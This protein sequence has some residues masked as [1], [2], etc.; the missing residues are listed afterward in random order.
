MKPQ[1]PDMLAAFDPKRHGGELM[2][3][4]PLGKEVRGGGKHPWG[5][6]PAPVLRTALEK[7][8][9]ICGVCEV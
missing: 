9:A 7:L 2:A 1:L 5:K 8:G 4:R 3:F 6:V